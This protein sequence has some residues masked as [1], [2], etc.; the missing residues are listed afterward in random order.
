FYPYYNTK[1]IKYTA[2][3]A[4]LQTITEEKC[5]I[6]HELIERNQWVLWK[7]EKVMD[8][9]TGK[10]KVDKKTGELLFTKVPYQINGLPAKATDPNTWASYQDV[11]I[12]KQHYSGIGYV[13]TENDDYTAID[14][15]NCIV[16]GVVQ[17]EAQSIVNSL[18]SY[19]EV[20]QSGEGL[21][22]FV[23]GKKPGDR[24]RNIEKGIEMYDN[25][26]Y[27]AMTGNHLEGTPANINEAQDTINYLY[28]M[29]SPNKTERKLRKEDGS[30]L[31]SPKMTDD[32]VI[33]KASNAKNGDKFKTLYS[34]DVSSY[35]SHSEADQAL[36][37]LIAPYT[38]DYEQIDRIFSNS[39]LYREKWD[40]DDYKTNTIEN[41]VYDRGF[42]YKPG[43]QDFQLHIKNPSNT[44]LRKA[45]QERRFKE[46]EKMQQEW[47]LNGSR[48]RKPSTISPV[49][50]SI[51]LPEYVDFILFDLE[52]NTRV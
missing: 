21:H 48:G 24:S 16:D 18:N 3:G 1:L 46:L 17:D 19:T 33:Q 7:L 26:R 37:N 28:E 49:R 50:C 15:D 43:T 42:T 32:E 51:I 11:N 5:L 45:L 29:L 35:G 36:C 34:G 41:A 20:S 6:P 12:H 38:Q 2:G 31:S 10:Q 47:E 22:I 23:K 13:L 52:E 4:N 14:L 8:K 44:E 27:I 9:E 40:R 30:K 39:G 25:K